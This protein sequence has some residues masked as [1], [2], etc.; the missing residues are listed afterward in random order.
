MEF[1]PNLIGLAGMHI[2]M[3]MLPGPNTVLVSW[4]AAT[5]SRRHGLKAV[6]GVVLASLVWV[7]LALWGVGALLVEA[8]G[9]YR[10]LRIAGAA[11]LIYVGYRMLR[12]GWAGKTSAPGTPP[13]LTNRSPFLTGITTT[14]SNPK[15]A[16]FWTSAFLLAVPAHAPGWVYAAILL[17][18]AVQST[19]WYG[20]LALFFS[21]G[22]A[23]RL[24]LRI[25]GYLDLVAGAVMIALGLKLADELRREIVAETVR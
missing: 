2:M 23:Q 3:A 11:Y 14:L 15:S 17:I 21:A 5:Q 4:Y 10:L 19:L 6:A 18:V 8:G 9:L 20:A 16:V 12:A 1:L 25:T 7:S 13:T 24:Y 22:F